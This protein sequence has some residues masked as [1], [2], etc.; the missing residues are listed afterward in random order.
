LPW[1]H[2]TGGSLVRLTGA[3]GRVKATE[4]RSSTA[5]VCGE[6][7]DELANPLRLNGIEDAPLFAPR[8]QKPR[9]FEMGEVSRHGGGGDADLRGNLA[10]RESV[11]GVSHQEPE[12]REAVFLG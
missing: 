3:S 4:F 9:A 12:D 1:R 7:R 10:R 8:T 11:G 6:K 5:A 2:I